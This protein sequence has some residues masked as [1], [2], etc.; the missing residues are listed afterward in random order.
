MCIRDRLQ[1]ADWRTAHLGSVRRGESRSGGQPKPEN[2]RRI[3]VP[4]PIAATPPP[5]TSTG[6]PNETTRVAACVSAWT[7]P[8]RGAGV[9]RATDRCATMWDGRARV[10]SVRLRQVSAGPDL[11]PAYRRPERAE[12]VRQ[13]APR[14]LSCLLY[15]SPSP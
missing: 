5:P 11:L 15:T 12:L 1:P 6:E 2:R 10:R 9:G 13:P 4:A 14:H 8:W 3:R 7:A